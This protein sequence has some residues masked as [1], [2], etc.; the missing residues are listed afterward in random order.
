MPVLQL[1]QRQPNH[2][3]VKHLE[4]LLAAAYNGELVG[5]SGVSLYENGN[6]GHCF[7]GNC[8]Q[9][10]FTTLKLLDQLSKKILCEED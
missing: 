3:L 1:I 9:R 7:M 10:P 4:T 6:V 2:A 5:M 8:V